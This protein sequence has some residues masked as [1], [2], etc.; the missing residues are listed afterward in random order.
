M[1]I[2]ETSDAGRPIVISEPDSMHAG[3][4]KTIAASIWSGLTGKSAKPSA[5]KI[6]IE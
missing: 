2:R 6:V 4:Y 1:S 3:L 5:P